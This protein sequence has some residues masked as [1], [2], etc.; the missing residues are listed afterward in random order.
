MINENLEEGF[1][2]IEE[3]PELNLKINDLNFE[4]IESVQ[5]VEAVD[6]KVYDLKV[7]NMYN[8]QV[9]DLG[10]VHNGGGK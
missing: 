2:F 9:K 10:I 4:E 6:E 5:I 8:Y 1:P 3:I 7:S